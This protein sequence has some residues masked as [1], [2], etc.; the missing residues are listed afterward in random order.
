MKVSR[1]T[2]D[3]FDARCSTEAIKTTIISETSQKPK[4]RSITNEYHIPIDDVIVII[5]QLLR[6]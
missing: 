4:D 3:R 1:T 2:N 6:R 5:D